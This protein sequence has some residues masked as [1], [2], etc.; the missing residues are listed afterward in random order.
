MKTKKKV[1]PKRKPLPKAP[2]Q[3][4]ADLAYWKRVAAALNNGNPLPN[5]AGKFSVMGFTYRNRATFI[6]IYDEW[7]DE[8]NKTITKSIGD[9]LE[10]PG[11]LA[12]ILLNLNQYYVAC[13][14]VEGI[15]QR[16]SW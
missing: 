12:E 5:G 15:I 9:T 10:V 3:D 2:K 11:Y 8:Q 4:L 1:A 7:D 13:C 14:D 16:F 6:R